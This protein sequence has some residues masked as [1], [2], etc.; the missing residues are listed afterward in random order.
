MARYRK[1]DPRIWNDAKFRGMTDE[2]KLVFFFLL[3]H[4]NM[5]AIGAMR[6]T[7]P[8]MAAELGWSIERF[9]KGFGE[10]FRKG[11][12]KHDER[13][14]FV[15]LPN[16]IK[17]NPPENPNV[18]KA[19]DASIDYLPECNMLNELLQHV[20]GFLEELPKGFQEPFR[21]GL[22]NQ[23]Q[24]QEQEQYILESLQDSVGQGCPTVQNPNEVEAKKTKAVP[25]ATIIDHLNKVCKCQFKPSSRVTKD[26]IKARWNEGFRVEDFI[27]V[28][29]F[30][31]DEW[32]GD[33]KMCRFLRPQTLFGTKFESYLVA[34]RKCVESGNGNAMDPVA[35]R[36]KEIEKSRNGKSPWEI[37]KEKQNA[38]KHSNAFVAPSDSD[39]HQTG[40]C[41][42]QGGNGNT[43]TMD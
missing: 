40:R 2:G 31:A 17:Y 33:D 8:G 11:I 13:A 9:R 16:F 27:A 42:Q 35:Q 18:V 23:E 4:P 43:K 25:Y 19:W 21:K 3:T 12:V 20:K 24:E 15:W 37:A 34:S 26:N 1:I 10:P 30:K 29:D 38:G 36:L 39:Q 6:H 28:I 14:S 22:A 41:V 5:T 7:V 32:A